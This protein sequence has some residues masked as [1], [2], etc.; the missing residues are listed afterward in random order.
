MMRNSLVTVQN[1]RRFNHILDHKSLATRTFCTLKRAKY[2]VTKYKK[3][4]GRLKNRRCIATHY[5]RSLELYLIAT[6][7]TIMV[8]F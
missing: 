1:I 4:F 2:Y 3:L 7:L 8:L 6:A 5:D